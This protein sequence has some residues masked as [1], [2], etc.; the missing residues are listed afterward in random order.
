MNE[1]QYQIVSTFGR[2]VRTTLGAVLTGELLIYP[3]QIIFSPILLIRLICG[4]SVSNRVCSVND[5]AYFRVFSA[6]GNR[7]FFEA[8]MIQLIFDLN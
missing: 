1:S 3:V 8:G 2:F 7:G 4:Y 6:N 5:R